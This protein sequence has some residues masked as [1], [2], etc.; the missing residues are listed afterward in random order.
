MIAG[1]Y[2]GEMFVSQF[3]YTHRQLSIM[4]FVRD[5]KEV[6]PENCRVDIKIPGLPTQSYPV[7][8]SMDAATLD[9]VRSDSSLMFTSTFACINIL[10]MQFSEQGRVIV[11]VVIGD[12]VIRAGSLKIS[13]HPSFAGLPT[14]E[15]P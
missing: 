3:P 13:L 7:E 9:S 6:G 14:A 15:A 4:V 11:D 5:D 10:D 2:T 8:R 12:D 1:M